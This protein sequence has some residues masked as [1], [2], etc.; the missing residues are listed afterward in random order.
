[1]NELTI[2]EDKQF[3]YLVAELKNIISAR[4]GNAATEI[5][6]MYFEVGEAIVNS[7]L[8]KKYSKGSQSLIERVGEELGIRSRTT[9]YE[10]INAYKTYQTVSICMETLSKKLDKPYISWTDVV[11]DSHPEKKKE[12]VCKHCPLHCGAVHNSQLT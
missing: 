10:A 11:R 8:Y 12:V 5:L 7:P 4:R 6:N 3:D 9:L 2:P 1:M